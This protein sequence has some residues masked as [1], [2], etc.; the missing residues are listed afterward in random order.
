[1]DFEMLS[2]STP[3]RHVDW[4]KKQK[5]KA[6]VLKMKVLK[7]VISTVKGGERGKRTL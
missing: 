4:K 5:R 7:Q 3:E 6:V 1:M 2:F